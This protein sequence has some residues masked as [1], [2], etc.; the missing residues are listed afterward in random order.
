MLLYIAI[1]NLSLFVTAQEQ[2]DS[3]AVYEFIEQSQ[4]AE[5]GTEGLKLANQANELANE[6]SLHIQVDAKKNLLSL[7]M[8]NNRSYDGLRTFLELNKVLEKNN[9]WE[10]IVYNYFSLGDYYARNGMYA[11]AVEK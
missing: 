5:D 10:D 4:G 2:R 3:L 6:M 7:Q 1:F 9:R 8:Q 11:S